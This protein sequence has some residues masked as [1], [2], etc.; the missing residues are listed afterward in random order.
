MTQLL[1]IINM[2]EESNYFNQLKEDYTSLLQELNIYPEKIDFEINEEILN[3]EIGKSAYSIAYPIQGLLKYHGMSNEDERIA[4]FSSIS[5]N[6]SCAKTITYIK[7]LD[8]NQE[9]QF[10]INGEKLEEKNRAYQ[11]ILHQI[12][13]IQSI[14]KTNYS[15]FITSRNVME[16]TG[17]IA[18]GKGLGTSASAGAAI[19][20]ALNTLLFQSIPELFNNIQ[21]KSICARYLAGS[22]SRSIVGGIGLWMSYPNATSEESFALRLDEEGSDF[23]RDISLITVALPLDFKT[24]QAHAHSANSPFF[25]SWLLERKEKIQTF[26]KALKNHNFEKLGEM[27]EY[28][29][30]CLHSITMTSTP[31]NPIILWSPDT[32]SIMQNAIQMRK[33]GIPV[34]FSIDTGPSTV[35]ITKNKYAEKIIQQLKKINPDF[36]IFIGKIAGPSRIIK[37]NSKDAQLLTQD[38]QKFKL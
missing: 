2:Q 17:D 21:F 13:F 3:Q 27:V 11:R 20:E 10:I 18:I 12:S 24:E 28:D 38:I 15:L 29:T 4:Y 32:I 23:I 36:N 30:M 16:E 1:V 37:E 14:S 9:N 26:N 19:S 5:L 25:K 33:N 34:Y 22:A 6:N 35:L 7:L 31:Q 8:S